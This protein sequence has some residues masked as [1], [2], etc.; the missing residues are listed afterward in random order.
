[1]IELIDTKAGVLLRVRAQ[2]GA[3]RNAVVGAHDGALRIAVAA[4]PDK[5]K[6][7][8]AVAQ[9]LADQLNLPRAAITL[10]TGAASR[11][12]TF[13]V[14]GSSLAEMRETLQKL[15]PQPKREK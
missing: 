7:N 1:V 5:G 13:L 6:A 4:P 3:K 12:K 9:L 2:P 15:M 14:T 10:R 11:Q 8:E